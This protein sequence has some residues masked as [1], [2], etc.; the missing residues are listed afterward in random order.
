MLISGLYFAVGS[1]SNGT[2]EKASKSLSRLARK[3]GG[4]VYIVY[5]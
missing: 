2:E 5:K 4:F 3:D 1:K